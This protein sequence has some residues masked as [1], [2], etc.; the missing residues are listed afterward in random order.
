[1]NS[2]RDQARDDGEGEH[3]RAPSEPVRGRAGDGERG[4]E[5]DRVAAEDRGEVG[6]GE[7][8]RAAV[9]QQQ[10]G[11]DVG[12]QRD[13]EQTEGQGVELAAGWGR[14][15]PHRPTLLPTPADATARGLHHVR[16]RR[17]GRARPRCSGRSASGR[18]GCRADRPSCAPRP[19]SGRGR[20]SRSAA[21]PRSG[22]W[23]R[24]RTGPRSTCRPAFCRCRYR[25]MSADMLGTALTSRAALS[26]PSCTS[27]SWNA[28]VT[29]VRSG[30]SGGRRDRRRLLRL[31][32]AAGRRAVEV[33]GHGVLDEGGGLDH[34]HLEHGA[35]GTGRDGH[36]RVDGEGRHLVRVGGGEPQHQPVALA[37]VVRHGEAGRLHLHQ[38]AGDHR[39]RR[40]DADPELGVD[41]RTG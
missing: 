12:A 32:G 1:M 31:R 3:E 21:A 38:L 39:L 20:G 17:P 35:A 11:R 33:E 28:T 4:D 18:R 30:A 9:D 41:A 22:C 8:E 37:Q 40:R 27:N 23:C 24:P 29:G 34:R 2:T 7:P 14:A 25:S 26:K 36:P 6:V 16:V 5:P 15:R 19:G 10:R 13:G